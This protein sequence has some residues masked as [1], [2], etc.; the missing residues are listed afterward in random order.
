MREEK[1]MNT[2][3]D[4]MESDVKTPNIG[5]NSL[6]EMADLCAEQAALEDEMRQL[7]E[8]LKAKAKAARKLSQEIIPAKMS[9]LGLES[10]TLKDGSSVK[11]KQLVQASIP[12]K[13]REE[14]FQWLRDNGHGDL[15]KNQVS[16]T[17]GKGED[18]SAS[19][20]IDKIEELGYQPNQKVWVEP[21][22]LKAFVREQIARGSELP[23]D[24]FGVFVGAETKI[25]KT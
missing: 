7:E 18:D 3:L 12:V 9:E 10:L 22:T 19:N 17:F 15:I 4:E 8:Q 1:L 16:A 14:A 11:V 2:L 6:K 23:M 5:D 24:K 21:M 20:F 25:S 13:Y